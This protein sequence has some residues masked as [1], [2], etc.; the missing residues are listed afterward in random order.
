MKSQ[1][2]MRAFF[3]IAEAFSKDP[4]GFLRWMVTGTGIEMYRPHIE[5]VSLMTLHAAKGLEWECVFIVGV[6]EGLLPYRL[7]EGQVSDIEEER[8]L[9]YVGMTRAK[10][11]LFLTH[12]EKRVLFGQEFRLP[13]SAFLQDLNEQ[14]F[15]METFQRERKSQSQQLRLF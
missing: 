4:E 13:R 5:T 9:L 7:F 12:A 8:R 10:S 14:W 15:Q 2:E 1:P 11:A 6:E 3:S